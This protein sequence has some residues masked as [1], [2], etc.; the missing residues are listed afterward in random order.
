MMAPG[1]AAHADVVR[2]FGGEVLAPDG[3]LDRKRLGA[4]VFALYASLNISYLWYN[5]IGCAACV[6]F[7]LVLQ[8]ALGPT[9]GRAEAVSM[10]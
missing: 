2:S 8:A 3:S 1:G 10:P 4:L 7:S 5:V 6:L 9:A